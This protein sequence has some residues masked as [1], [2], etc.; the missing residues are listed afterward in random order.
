M[1]NLGEV[2]LQ[3]VVGAQTD[4]QTDLEEVGQ[5]VPLVR[6]EQRVVTQRAHR[7]ANLLKVEQILER[8][9]LAQQYAVRDGVR[10]QEG[11]GEMLG[12]ACLATVGPKN[13]CA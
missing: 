4:V 9:D 5:R 7:K 3:R 8:G 12:V 13:E 6:Q 2:E 11:R 1:S 10:S